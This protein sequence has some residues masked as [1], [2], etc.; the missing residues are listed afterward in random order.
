MLDAD[1]VLAHFG[2]KGMKWGKRK[3]ENSSPKISRKENRQLNREAAADFYEN[4]LNTIYGEA[5]K[6]GDAVLIKTR[7]PGEYASTILTGKEFARGLEAGGMLDIKVTEV[8]ARQPKPKS[9]YVLNDDEIG[10]YKKQD[11]RKG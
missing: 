5:K 4:K 2:V 7:D 11:F 3:G 9:Q 1:D 6:K 10:T 8:Y